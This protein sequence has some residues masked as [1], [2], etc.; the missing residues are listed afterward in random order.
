MAYDAAFPHLLQPLSNQRV[1]IGVQLDVIRDR[2]VD[3]IAA[4]PFLRGGQRIKGFNLFGDGTETD[5]FLVAAHNART[6]THIIPYYNSSVLAFR[7]MSD[8]RG[9]IVSMAQRQRFFCTIVCFLSGGGG[10]G[11]R[12]PETL[13]GL[14]VFKTGDRALARW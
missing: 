14:T 3:E 9:K 2:L 7:R 12:T 10:G 8:S 4:G 6:I 5:S 13:S 11:I 1:L